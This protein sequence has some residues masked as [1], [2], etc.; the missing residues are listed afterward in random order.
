M[1]VE[2]FSCSCKGLL[3]MLSHLD[4]LETFWNQWPFFPLAWFIWT[5]VNAAITKRN[6]SWVKITWKRCSQL[7]RSQTL[8]RFFYSENTT[9]PATRTNCLDMFCLATDAKRSLVFMG[10][11][12]SYLYVLLSSHSMDGHSVHIPSL[13][14]TNFTLSVCGAQHL[15]KCPWRMSPPCCPKL[16]CQ[17]F[18]YCCH[19]D[20][21][22][23]QYKTRLARMRQWCK[24]IRKAI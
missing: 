8:E 4:W 23:P 20:D 12:L 21:A 6:N 1:E 19:R 9:D 17:S 11:I 14:F 7:H 2:L 22:A 13:I 16:T 3:R 24:G 15:L 18:C 10:S 5:Y